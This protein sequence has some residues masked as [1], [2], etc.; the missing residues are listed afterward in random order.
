MIKGMVPFEILKIIFRLLI[1]NYFNVIL[2]DLVEKF[3]GVIFLL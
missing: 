1:F 3:F 2:N